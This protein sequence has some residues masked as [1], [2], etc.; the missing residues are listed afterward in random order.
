MATRVTV[1]NEYRHE[2]LDEA[3]SK[4][5][6]E[7]IHGAIAQALR[8]G[9]EFIVRT[10][11]LDEPEHGLTQEVLDSTDVLL[12]WGH[13]AHQEVN[14]EIVERVQKRVLCGMGLIVL[15]S[16]HHSKIF[17]KL[18]GTSCN[19]KWR[20]AD[21][22]ERIW[23]IEPGHPIA[24]GLDEYFELEKE[25]MYGERFDI[26]EPDTLVF[27]GWFQGGEVFRSGCC[28]HRGHGKVFYFQ[29][30][31]ESY[32]IYYNPNVVKVIRNAAKWAKPVITI[33]EM[34]CPNAQPLEKIR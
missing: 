30:G 3:I 9:E 22:K 23:V 27:V 20:E 14:D 16:G 12:W 11:T 21:E 24:E 17:R 7:G 29:P 18:M 5:Y 1:W 13:M 26:P 8:E 32:P 34:N 4:V 10:A 25:E 2:K 31:H 6:P 15:H 33:T 28:Y 19:L